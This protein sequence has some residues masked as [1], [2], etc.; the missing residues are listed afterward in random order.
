MNMIA[1][2]KA[3]LQKAFRF[4]RES[5]ATATLV[6]LILILNIL[7]SA[8]V[9]WFTINRQTDADDMGMALSVDDTSALYKAYMYDLE[10]EK[11]TNKAP[12]GSEL[13]IGNLVLNQY[14]TIFKAQNRYTPA[15]ARIEITR[16]NSM[17]KSGN[18]TLTVA[19]DAT[20]GADDAMSAYSSS[21][22]RFTAFIIQDKGDNDQSLL[23]DPA[24]F[25]DYISPRTRFKEIENLS[26]A[27]DHSKTFVNVVGEGDDHTHEKL[28]KITLSIPYTADNWYRDASGNDVM[29][30]YLYITYDVQLIECYMD[31]QETASGGISLDDN[32]VIFE[33]DFKKVTVGYT[34]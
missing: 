7:I 27:H 23:A 18:V 28:D 3:S 24:A 17:P 21:I 31:K 5:R 10:T 13:T 4:L 16:I 8:S 6:M 29:N 9:A 33:N 20:I 26:G 34:D 2:V 25:Y 22:T 30:V 11:G 12:D 32:G 14:D 15:F 19:R 1:A